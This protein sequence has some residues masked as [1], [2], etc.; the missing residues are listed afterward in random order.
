MKKAYLFFVIFLT[1]TFANPQS[2]RVT[3]GEVN[4]S[5]DNNLVIINQQSNK[6]I[7][8]WQEFSIANNETTKF[9]Q[10][11]E[12]AS[13]LN[14]VISDKPSSLYGNLEANGKVYLVN[15]NGIFIGPDGQ[16]S[17]MTFIASTLNMMDSEFLDGK[18]INLFANENK[19]NVCKIENLGKIKASKEI[20]LISEN[21]EN[22]G[23]LDAEDVKIIASNNVLIFEKGENNFV[24]RKNSL[25]SLSDDGTIKAAQVELKAAGGNIYSLAINQKG[26]INATGIENKNGKIILSASQGEVEINGSLKAQSLDKG[27]EINLLGDYVHIKDKANIDVSSDKDGGT[28]LIG[29]DYQGK[30]ENIKNAKFVYVEEGSK[31]DASSKEIGNGGKVI[32]WSDE[33]TGFFGN[34]KANGGMKSGDGG[35]VEISSKKNL[36]FPGLVDLNALNGKTG[37]LL[38]DPFNLTISNSADN[39]GPGRWSGGNPNT[40]AAAANTDN[41]LYSDIVTKLASANVLITTGAGGSASDGFI[42]IQSLTPHSITWS[43]AN[44]LTITADKSL[45]I[46]SGVTINS[47]HSGSSF[48][49]MNFS[50]G[51]TQSGNFDGIK[52]QGVLES[53]DGNITLSGKGGNQDLNSGISIESGTI[54]T[55]PTTTTRGV[56]TITGHGGLSTS[57]ISNN[58]GVDIDSSTISTTQGEIIIDGTG[59]GTNAGEFNLGVI[60]QESDIK[61][62]SATKGNSDTSIS[63]T[64]V[65]KPGTFGN[66]GVNLLDVNALHETSAASG[67]IIINGTADGTLTSSQNNG[68]LIEDYNIFATN[69]G[70]I[71]ITAQGSLANTSNNDGTSYGL[72]VFSVDDSADNF[73][74]ENGHLTITA[75]GGNA[76]AGF[77][78]DNDVSH[79]MGVEIMSTGSGNVTINATGGTNGGAGIILN[80]TRVASNKIVS[81]GTGQIIITATG[82]SSGNCNGFIMQ[83]GAQIESTS[84]AITIDATG[85]TAFLGSFLGLDMLSASSITSLGSA[86]ITITATGSDNASAGLT[87]ASGCTI[88]GASATGDITINANFVSLSG[89][90]RSTG[91]LI[92][93]PLNVTDPIDILKSSS[94]FRL[95][96]TDLDSFFSG[97][98]NVYIGYNPLGQHTIVIGTGSETYSFN[99][100]PLIISGNDIDLNATL[101]SGNSGAQNIT[102]NV[103]QTV[104]STLNLEKN[105]ILTSG[106][107]LINGGAN[108]DIFNIITTTLQK[109]SLDGGLGINTLNGPNTTNNW[110]V[111]GANSG[112]LGGSSFFNFTRIQDI[113]GGSGNDSVA[114]PNLVNS[115]SITANNQISFYSMTLTSIEK[116]I[117]GTNSDTFTFTGAF[118]ISGISGIGIDGGVTGTHTIVGPNVN[119]IWGVTSAN[120]GSITPSGAIGP[121]DFTNIQSLTGGTSDDVF[122]I[123]NGATL[124]GSISG[125]S[126]GINTINYDYSTPIRVNISSIA[127]SGATGTDEN[128]VTTLSIT[129]GFSHITS[130]NGGTAV[131][132]LRGT[133]GI[134]IWD[135]TNNDAGTLTVGANSIN[136]GF[137]GN[138]IG[139]TNN[140]TFNITDAKTLSGTINGGSGGVNTI[141]YNYTTPISINISS[142]SS[143]GSTG[144]DGGITQGFSHITD[145]NGGSSTNS[146]TNIKNTGS[147]TWNITNN[148]AGTLSDGTNT[149]TFNL[150]QNLVG[151]T[152]NDTFNISNTKTL[153]GTING[154]SGGTNIINYNY[155]T[156]ISV[157]ITSFGVHG[158]SGTDGGI[159]NGFSNITNIKGGS[160]TNTLL[161]PNGTNVWNILSINAGTLV[162]GTNSIGFSLFQNLTGGSGNDSFVFNGGSISGNLNGGGLVGQQNTLDYSNLSSDLTITLPP[163]AA[164]FVGGVVSNINRFIGGLGDDTINI[165]G[166][167]IDVIETGGTNIFEF[168]AGSNVTNTVVGGSG[169]DSFFIHSGGSIGGSLIGGRGSNLLDYEDFPAYGLPVIVNLQAGSATGIGGT[170]SGIST[171]IADG[172]QINTLI[173]ILAGGF[174][175]INGTNSGVASDGTNFFN[176]G[177]L[178]GGDLKD[179]YRFHFG[180]S[181]TGNL[182]GGLGSNTIT[183]NVSPEFGSPITIDLENQTVTGIGGTF[184][185]VAKISADDSQT[186][187]LIGPNVN[188]TW[189]IT[190]NNTGFVNFV[191]GTFNFANIQ[192]LLGGTQGDT[193]I[194][195]N[196]VGLSGYIDGGNDPT[197]INTLDYSNY[198]TEVFVDLAAHTATNILGGVFRI[199]N[200]I[201]PVHIIDVNITAASFTDLFLEYDLKRFCDFNNY[202][203]YF[204]KRDLINVLYE[205]Q[206][207]Y[208]F[209]RRNQ[210]IYNE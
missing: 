16:I 101:T 198:T 147:F 165:D 91:N 18:D 25:G 77:A 54:S 57:A 203:L 139:E 94:N 195:A 118:Q 200:V 89:T 151:S 143:T 130:I 4:I 41:I 157:T 128:L 28:I 69:D 129:H 10:P 149:I 17:A 15:Q 9:I 50:G 78:M 190:D 120:T 100:F 182:F 23:L 206:E 46:Q 39:P 11:S 133:G 8:N 47:T 125:G 155:T 68:V 201:L 144:S 73:S 37:T 67:K 117:G 191:G 134:N 105:V 197:P 177:N 72:E 75:N 66:H 56:I 153:S 104:G 124:T 173:G 30:N 164:P 96:S 92:V 48:T 171:I 196:Q 87:L 123:S 150:F 12:N 13:I 40:W 183:Y 194:L 71:E 83:K 178:V 35:F 29:G 174:W 79:S 132:T 110:N 63:I 2:G 86:P 109:A 14:R 90:I 3:S 61:L 136:F 43:T 207:F 106:N 97:F 26:V 185:G 137:F 70:S 108:N 163:S 161:R 205:D 156:P 102:L 76:S 20:Y 168:N 88:G 121:T 82:G 36:S 172:T 116:L 42:T 84:G 158:A 199:Q 209:K 45:T 166:S 107:L 114:G 193:F 80:P 24:I 49:A 169:D 5:S 135:I 154:G 58:F 21:V 27:G 145:I 74:V 160:A 210:I 64:G 119:N 202:R 51:T 187:L 99:N 131:N 81:S 180:S 33:A 140:D 1:N 148:N 103:G 146:L 22:K 152:G 59:G 186:N 181:I 204:E 141:N 159:T 7:V 176:F 192:N 34:I 170:F 19:E 122:D 53:A 138:L 179:S 208:N 60:I 115:W 32:L 6:A 184:S 93:R 85:T 111:T 167:M 175:D 44:T 126:S 127:A 189:N 55:A 188:A 65:G 31:I 52:M 113:N 142:F 162:N 98:S 38:L 95:L 112:N 62:T